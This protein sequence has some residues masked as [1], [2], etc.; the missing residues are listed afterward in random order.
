M[1]AP[2][3][4]FPDVQRVITNGLAHL[5][6]GIDH[7]DITTPPDLENMLPFIRVRRRS[8]PRDR[9]NDYATVEID[10]FD[11]LYDDVESLAETATE[12]LCGPPPPFWQFDRI[13]ADPAP[14]ELPWGDET[15]I[16]RFGGTYRIT[17]RRRAVL[18]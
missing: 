14:R 17:S 7:T 12:Y 10:Y 11:K 9:L 15:L 1:T 8:G 5:V 4:R 3:R 6:G 2:V 18:L 13:E 16:L